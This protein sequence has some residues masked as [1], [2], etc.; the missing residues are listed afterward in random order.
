MKG[1]ARTVGRRW[2][3]LTI[4]EKERLKQFTRGFK[5]LGLI[6][7]TEHRENK[8]TRRQLFT[9]RYSQQQQR[10][11]P[12]ALFQ[13]KSHDGCGDVTNRRSAG[14]GGLAKFGS[15]SPEA[16][17][18]LVSNEH[19]D[20]NRSQSRFRRSA[21]VESAAK[22]SHL[23]QGVIQYRAKRVCCNTGVQSPTLSVR[24]G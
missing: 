5:G 22:D 7:K 2:L 20:P 10:H 12:L 14:S 11:Q 8:K 23:R 16:E 18:S 13:F 6:L 21:S 9:N 4:T 15:T 3:V 1:Q 17:E 19:V 24:P